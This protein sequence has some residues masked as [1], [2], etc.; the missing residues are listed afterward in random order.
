MDNNNIFLKRNKTT[1][2]IKDEELNNIKKLS[3]QEHQDYQLHENQKTLSTFYG[4]EYKKVEKNIRLKSV[5]SVIDEKM[6]TLPEVQAQPAENQ[7]VPLKHKR[8]RTLLKEGNNT[9]EIVE[10]LMAG[11]GFKEF[12]NK[13]HVGAH[14]KGKF[15]ALKE[16]AEKTEITYGDNKKMKFNPAE[17]TFRA[18]V[19]AGFLGLFS[20]EKKEIYGAKLK[21]VREYEERQKQ[22]ME[23]TYGKSI[24]V[25]GKLRKHVRERIKTENGVN[26]YKYNIAGAQA[27]AGM[28]RGEHSIENNI[29]YMKELGQARI[30]A[31]INNYG[32]SDTAPKEL[33]FI[34]RGH[35][36]GGAAA[37]NGAMLIKQ[38]ALERTEGNA[39]LRTR[40]LNNLKFELI[41]HDPVPGYG[42]RSGVN[43]YANL[44]VNN[45][46]TKEE[47]MAALGD[48]LV[49]STV[50]YSMHTEH[51]SFFTPQK[52]IGAKRIIL[53]P[54][55]HG[56]GLDEIQHA[57]T[58]ENGK[59]K[60]TSHS[61]TWYDSKTKVRYR[62]A[63]ISE[64]P[65]GL[66]I[67]KTN[68]ELVRMENA[69][70]AIDIYKTALH[71]D[72]KEGDQ[73]ERHNIIEDVINDYFGISYQDR[74]QMSKI[75]EDGA[76]DKLIGLDQT[77]Q[78]LLNDN[79]SKTRL[80]KGIVKEICDRSFNVKMLDSGSD[81]LKND[82]AFIQRAGSLLNMC[83][84]NT[85]YKGYYDLLPKEVRD[86]LAMVEPYIK[87]A[88]MK[89]LDNEAKIPELSDIS[90]MHDMPEQ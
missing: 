35:S 86:H 38:Y 31:W 79:D 46:R 17:F 65:E 13:E 63:G 16:L 57:V 56:T 26:I 54:Y 30:D 55:R 23:E 71:R 44:N 73:T 29:K 85:E 52:V 18:K 66:Y 5:D 78:E 20:S 1:L 60:F 81:F 41:Q 7:W 62:G 19:W 48:N 47:G 14:A 87:A 9:G 84:N 64:L 40:L 68:G 74:G 53:T 22:L 61:Q 33:R 69:Q 39:E 83:K 58:A 75:A 28:N 3:D 2:N 11:T 10:F 42:S 21:A 51:D 90:A 45:E 43:E 70:T 59:V 76:V 12:R 32:K 67:Q 50:F 34:L 72:H 88:N 80:V 24:K 49:E 36:R 77:Q 4:G 89:L 6:K 37:L 15:D 82:K 25:K 8:S 27:L